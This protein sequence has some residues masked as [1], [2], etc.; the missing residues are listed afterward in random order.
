MDCRGRMNDSDF[1]KVGR[2]IC[3]EKV[4]Y[5][6][7]GRESTRTRRNQFREREVGRDVFGRNVENK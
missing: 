4:N 7:G 2:G 6:V 1:N 3:C 5:Q